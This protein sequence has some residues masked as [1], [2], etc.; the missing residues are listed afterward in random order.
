M[1]TSSDNAEEDREGP[2]GDIDGRPFYRITRNGDGTCDVWLTPG[3]AIEEYDEA[4]HQ[5]HYRICV[6]GMTGIEWW[7]GIEEDIRRRYQS[8]LDSAEEITI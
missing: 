2:S 5:I 1:P 3:I 6:R 4:Q 8:W 7:P